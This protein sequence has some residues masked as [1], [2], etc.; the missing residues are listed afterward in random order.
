MKKLSISLL[1]AKLHRQIHLKVNLEKDKRQRS[2]YQMPLRYVQ[3]RDHV[4]NLNKVV[5]ALLLGSTAESKVDV[6]I[7]KLENLDEVHRGYNGRMRV[8]TV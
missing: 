7:K 4:H 5:D 8:S 3:L 6:L 2:T 1:S